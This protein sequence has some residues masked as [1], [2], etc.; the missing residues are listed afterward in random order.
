M[1]TLETRQD[2]RTTESNLEM[3]RAAFGQRQWS[4][5]Y[6]FLGAADKEVQLNGQDLE[7]LA[8]VGFASNQL[9]EGTQTRERAYAAYEASH[10]YDGAAR[11]AVMLAGDYIRSHSMAVAGGWIN[12][13]NRL[14]GDLPESGGHAMQAFF[15]G[16]MRHFQGDDEGALVELRHA[17]EIARRVGAVD[18]EMMSQVCEAY[19]LVQLGQVEEGMQLVDVAMA[20]AVSGRLRPF[21]ATIVYCSTLQACVDVLDLGRALEWA[22]VAKKCCVKENLVPATGDCRLH[23]ASVLRYRGDWTEAEAEARDSVDE[24]GWNQGHIGEAMYEIGAIQLLRGDLEAAE[25]AF[26]RAVEFGHR[27]QP[28]LARLRLAQ[29]R[30]Q[31]ALSSI[32]EAV[33]EEAHPLARSRLLPAQVEIAL[34]AG[35]VDLAITA[36]ARLRQ[37]IAPFDSAGKQAELAC[38][39]GAVQL[40]AGDLVNAL[41]SC[42]LGAKLWKQIGSP[43]EAARAQVHIA[44]VQTARG[45]ADAAAME[46]RAAVATFERLGAVRDARR[47][48][49]ALTQLEGA[50][51]K[52]AGMTKT[53]RRA[54]MFTDIVKSTD[55]I[56]AIGDEAW[57]DVLRWHDQTLGAL[58]GK[59]H[60][61][62]VDHA[63]DGFLVVFPEANDALE[64][65]I[66]IQRKLAEHRRSHGFAPQLRI[67]VHCDV[68][69]FSGRHYSGK[70]VHKAAR[71]A[72]LADGGEIIATRDIA[73]GRPLVGEPQTVQLKGL[74]EPVEVVRLAWKSA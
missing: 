55:L 39:E 43:Y 48:I 65:A 29:G 5:A 57:S 9:A 24:G 11:L 21:S 25:Q 14:L 50:L 23:R 47:A 10:D 34:A 4:A 41:A 20:A 64:C 42:R 46:L 53:V 36:V 73:Q 18:T 59:H 52:E 2:Q 37:D 66:E 62:E 33:N 8:E 31:A 74:D 49:S 51:E 7:A 15:Q 12:T 6:R 60:G 58:F 1:T 30:V 63:G 44:E 32:T 45:D 27:P 22:D 40:A 68:A 38:A 67:G 54:F 61:E 3:G 72:A 70:G 71:I 26:Q 28:G 19:S 56:S 17:T 13:A 69:T 16:M 35:N